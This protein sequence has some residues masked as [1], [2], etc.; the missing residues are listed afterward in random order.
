MIEC[1]RVSLGSAGRGDEH[2]LARDR[3]SVE[4]VEKRLEQRAV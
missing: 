2:R 4:D 3:V 1:E